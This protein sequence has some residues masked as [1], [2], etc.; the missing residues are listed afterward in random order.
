MKK[1]TQQELT[2]IKKAVCAA[3]RT[4]SGEIVP[5][6]A[7]RAG[8]G[9]YRYWLLLVAALTKSTPT[10]LHAIQMFYYL[11]LHKTEGR[12]GILLALYLKDRRVEVVADTGIHKK[13]SQKTWDGVV[14]I[15][16][17]AA[18]KGKVIDGFASGIKECGKILT[19]HFPAKRKNQNEL[20]DDLVRG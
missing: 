6:V 12:T 1:F 9:V 13:C 16:V 8:G 17:S 10:R 4:T 3:E 14:K 2:K 19:K 7:E 5:F 18:K 20:A 11:K 15:I